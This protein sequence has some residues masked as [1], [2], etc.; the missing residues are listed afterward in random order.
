MDYTIIDIPKITDPRGNLAVV[1]KA[2]IPFAIKRVYYL[3]DVPS[4]SHRGGHAHKECY[5]MLIAISGSFI[6]QLN[7]GKT[8]TE[9]FLNKPAKGLIVPTMVWRELTDFSSGAV[10]LALAS[11]DFSEE[12]YIRD[13]DKFKSLAAAHVKS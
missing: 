8:T 10:C 1:E 13:F 4:E 9:V 11:H 12:D 3:Y 7:D 2:S 6:V 5:T